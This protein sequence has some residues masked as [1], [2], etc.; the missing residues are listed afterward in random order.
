MRRFVNSQ[1]SKLIDSTSILETNL[2]PKD[3]IELIEE[4]YGYSNYGSLTLSSP[5]FILSPF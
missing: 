3:I 4:E 2:Q 5:N 1:T